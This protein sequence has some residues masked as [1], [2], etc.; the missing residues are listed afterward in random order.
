MSGIDVIVK[1]CC[2]AFQERHLSRIGVL[3]DQRGQFT[4]GVFNVVL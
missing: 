2:S 1:R 3:V 4:L